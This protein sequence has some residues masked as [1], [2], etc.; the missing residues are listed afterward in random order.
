MTKQNEMPERIWAMSDRVQKTEKGTWDT[1]EDDPN[2]LNIP[3]SKYLRADTV[4]SR[5]KYNSLL[6]VAK[7]MAG[8]L[9]E[10]LYHSAPK[11]PGTTKKADAALAAFEQIEQE[12]E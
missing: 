12:G 10:Y 2:F 5:E 6:A 3:Y 8:G 4:V 11:Y 7:Q 9:T 1:V